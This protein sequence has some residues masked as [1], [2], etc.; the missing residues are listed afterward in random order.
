MKRYQPRKRCIIPDCENHRDEGTFIGDMCFPCAAY[1]KYSRRF[2]NDCHFLLPAPV[3]ELLPHECKDASRSKLSL[4]DYVEVICPEF[5]SRVGYPLSFDDACTAVEAEHGEQLKEFLNVTGL[6]KTLPQ[7]FWGTAGWPPTNWRVRG[8]YDDMIRG[9]ARLHLLREGFGGN[10]RSI[11]VVR[12]PDRMGRRYVVV[13]KRVVKTG[14]YDAPWSSG[15]DHNGEYEC[16]SGGLIDPKT[17]VLVEL[18]Y[19]SNAGE[20]YPAEL[21]HSRSRPFESGMWIE[22]CNV[23]LYNES[24][25][26][27][28]W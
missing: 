8:A 28:E 3:K 7:K 11:H 27:Q 4:G 9:M 26:G 23:R 15:P 25:E 12:R 2:Y 16:Y 1:S 21:T 6:H 14:L 10:H 13:S 22:R 18:G 5:V 20:L 24:S 17:H 19:K